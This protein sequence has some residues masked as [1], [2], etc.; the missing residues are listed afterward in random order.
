M[1]QQ[2]AGSVRGKLMIGLVAVAAVVGLLYAAHATDL[3]GLIL[4]LHAPPQGVH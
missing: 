1:Q 4:R 2:R 3:V